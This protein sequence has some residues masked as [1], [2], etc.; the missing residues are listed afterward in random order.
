M[1]TRFRNPIKATKPH[2]NSRW[3]PDQPLNKT[4]TINYMFKKLRNTLQSNNKKT[5]ETE[6][7]FHK[8]ENNQFFQYLCSD[9]Y[10]HEGQ[11]IDQEI[12]DAIP[13][14]TY[15]KEWK[16]QIIDEVSMKMF[17]LNI[18]S[19]LGFGVLIIMRPLN[20]DLVTELKKLLK[21]I[22]SPPVHEEYSQDIKNLLGGHTMNLKV[23]KILMPQ[24][25]SLE[26]AIQFIIEASPKEF[27]V[28]YTTI[29]SNFKG[30][31]S[32]FTLIK[33]KNDDL[34]GSFRYWFKMEKTSRLKS[35]LALNFGI[36]EDKDDFDQWYRREENEELPVYREEEVINEDD[37][38]P[39]Y[40]MVSC[41][42]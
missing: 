36:N 16:Y 34:I 26:T 5:Y 13:N 27:N 4:N 12:L 31:D 7:T 9:I 25:V 30:K 41:S 33:N 1:C 35:Y 24:D 8:G 17:Q 22:K 2:F 42:K 32:K 28:T 6:F 10:H 29:A 40:E 18:K 23:S 3:I 20:C 11:N 14:I 15:S 19:E 39:T 38:L 37:R 21:I